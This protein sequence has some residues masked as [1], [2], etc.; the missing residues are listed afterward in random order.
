MYLCGVEVVLGICSRYVPF[1]ALVAPPSSLH[2]AAG[3]YSFRLVHRCT[4]AHSLPIFS[5]PLSAQPSVNKDVELTQSLYWAG[6][7]SI[8]FPPYL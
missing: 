7:L 8:D 5:V 1:N 6:K 2:K 4:Y 3:N